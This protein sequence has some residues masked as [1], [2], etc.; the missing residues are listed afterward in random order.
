MN[1]YWH[2]SFGR[3]QKYLLHRL[4]VGARKGQV[5]HHKDGNRD[6]NDRSNLQ[7]L[8]SQGEHIRLHNPVRAR[9]AKAELARQLWA[10][11]SRASAS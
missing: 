3:K 9:W 6:N 8:N 4:I 1:G 2:I 10:K 5:V 7:I 11:V